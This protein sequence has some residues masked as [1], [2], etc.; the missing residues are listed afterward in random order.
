MKSQTEQ[1]WGVHINRRGYEKQSIPET[2]LPWIKPIE[3]SDWQSK[4][5][6]AWSEQA[7]RVEVLSVSHVLQLINFMRSND[8]WKTEG[9]PITRR[10]TQIIL[11]DNR[12]RK[13]KKVKRD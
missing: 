10:Y 1:T 8:T 7:Q 3:K 5:I 13:R 12:K 9:I 4:G 2:C 11:P 6:V